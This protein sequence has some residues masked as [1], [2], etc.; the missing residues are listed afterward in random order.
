MKVDTNHIDYIEKVV[1]TAVNVGLTNVII[2][3]SR[4]R[5]VSESTE[6]FVLHES[7][8]VPKLGCGPVC[9]TQLSSFLQRR[10]LMKG[11]EHECDMETHTVQIE[12]A[13]YTFARGLKMSSK[14][15]K[16]T[17]RFSNPITIRAPKKIKDA[18]VYHAIPVD[19]DWVSAL[20]TSVNIAKAPLVRFIYADQTLKY[21]VVDTVGDEISYTICDNCDIKIVD[22]A[23]DSFQ[24]DYEAKALCNIIKQVT[25]GYVSVTTLGM[26]EAEV[27]GITVY[28]KPRT[29][30]I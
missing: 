17:Y 7:P 18:T 6:I 28:L 12:N 25:V 27:N 16:V 9:V 13:P 3:D 2:E 10:A 21:S 14:K 1:Q 11:K 22:D 24:F 26:I 19:D 29:E 5:G 4:I 15:Y 30:Q 23:P 8:D 20:M